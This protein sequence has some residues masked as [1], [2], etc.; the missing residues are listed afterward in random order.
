[1]THKLELMRVVIG[2]RLAQCLFF[3]IGPI[4]STAQYHLDIL[5]QVA[6]CISK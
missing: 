2:A 4:D 5:N 6:Y 3:E 1:M